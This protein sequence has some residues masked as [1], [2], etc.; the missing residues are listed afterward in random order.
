M[1]VKF[2]D[3]AVPSAPRVTVSSG[4][5]VLPSQACPAF[6]QCTRDQTRGRALAIGPD[7]AK[8]KRQRALMTTPAAQALYKR[9][10]ETIEP[11]FGIIKEQQSG[12]RLLLRGLSNAG[13]EWSLL[14]VAFNLRMLARVWR[15]FLPLVALVLL[16][17]RHQSHL[18]SPSLAITHD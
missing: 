1:A 16:M 18:T 5:S 12:R 15:A 7:D 17:S 9:R 14:A 8:L 4:I 10:R 2:A 6:G 3:S 11:T 13:S